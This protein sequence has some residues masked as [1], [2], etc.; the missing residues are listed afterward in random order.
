MGNLNEFQLEF[1]FRHELYSKAQ[2]A[3]ANYLRIGPQVYWSFDFMRGK[4]L[5]R[6][7]ENIRC[8]ENMFNGWLDVLVD[9]DINF[10]E[11]FSRE[12]FLALR[13]EADFNWGDRSRFVEFF[14]KFEEEFAGKVPGLERLNDGV[15]YLI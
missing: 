3:Y 5:D 10:P 14:K 6:L 13:Q 8:A 7:V 4:K 15:D 1:V 12:R 9:S 11:W 2:T